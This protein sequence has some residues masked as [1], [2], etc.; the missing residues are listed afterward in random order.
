ML[1]T[2]TSNSQFESVQSTLNYIIPDG[3]KPVTLSNSPGAVRV[4]SNS[5]RYQAHPV[6][7]RNGRLV[8]GFSLENEGFVFEGGD[9]CNNI[10]YALGRAYQILN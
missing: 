7:I 3:E 10:G 2:S 8:S 6:T 1:Q 5:G 9:S 4:T